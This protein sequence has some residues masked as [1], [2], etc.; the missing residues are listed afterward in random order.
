MLRSVSRIRQM[1]YFD[2]VVQTSLITIMYLI[3]QRDPDAYVFFLGLILG[4]WQ[5]LSAV[6]R[7]VLEQRLRKVRLAY[8]AVSSLYLF[9]I[10]PLVTGNNLL[11]AIDRPTTFILPGV[12]AF[13]YY[14]ITIEGLYA[15][16]EQ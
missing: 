7:A 2:F 4:P 10:V 14:L 11:V 12:L 6:V 13:L 9:V 1:K 3:H 5:L 16:K 8:L 15:K